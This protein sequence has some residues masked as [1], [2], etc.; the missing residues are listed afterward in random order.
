MG[1][2][3]LWIPKLTRLITIVA[4]GLGLFGGFA[5]STM[6]GGLANPALPGSTGVSGLYSLELRRTPPSPLQDDGRDRR[7]LGELLDGSPL[8]R[9]VIGSSPAQA[10]FRYQGKRMDGVRVGLYNGDFF[11]MLGVVPAMGVLPAASGFGQAASPK[12]EIVLGHDL[13]RSMGAPEIGSTIE[14]ASF[15]SDAKPFPLLR[16]A[17]VAPPG[18]AGPQLRSAQQAWLAWDE[19]PGVVYPETYSR[20]DA[21]AQTLNFVAID[22][23]G[24][25]RAALQAELDHL[26]MTSGALPQQEGTL[27]LEPAAA[28]PVRARRE[29]LATAEALRLGTLVLVILVACAFGLDRWLV[30]SRQRF[31]LSIRRC[32]GESPGRS[33]G[34][35]ALGAAIDLAIA[36]TGAAALAWA[37]MSHYEALASAVFSVP[38]EDIPPLQP[39]SGL[40]LG[41]LMGLMG[42]I[43]VPLLFA[44]ELR[45]WQVNLRAAVASRQRRV[46]SVAAG[47]G[48]MLA[49]MA[50]SLSL[51][52][53]AQIDHWSRAD[54]GFS[55]EGARLFSYASDD[56][57]AGLER[58]L[59][60]EPAAPEADMFREVLAGRVAAEDIV[61]SSSP[62]FGVRQVVQVMVPGRGANLPVMGWLNDVSSNYFQRFRIRLLAGGMFDPV[63]RDE[64]VINQTMARQFFASENPIGEHLELL[65][66]TI[67]G[68]AQRYR[69]AGVVADAHYLDPRGG[70]IPMIYRPLQSKSGLSSVTVFGASGN[71]LAVRLN[72]A[73][74]RIEPHW[75]LLDHGDGKGLIG[76]MLR[77]SRVRNL[78]LA[79]VLLA[80]L[81]L[82]ALIL[83]NTGGHL[84]AEHRREVAIMRAL[85]A[86]R[87]RTVADLVRRKLGAGLLAA[88]FGSLLIMAV[89]VQSVW[90]ELRVA[91]LAGIWVMSLAVLGLF[92]ALL[93][94]AL[95]MQID[96]RAIA[97]HLVSDV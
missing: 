89:V 53:R 7:F 54:L 90:P 67:D 20:T 22:G 94:F 84:L 2:R 24:M 57:D 8:A 42:L 21:S 82:A 68:M 96:D 15:S 91:E 83:L 95:A 23:R 75:H 44:P 25:S 92:S 64:I 6:H 45:Q 18:F 76:F 71:D 32:L 62:P 81:P 97:Q 80:A 38:P 79:A 72:D 55:L 39:D 78:V 28:V 93:G 37:W 36:A 26:G 27:A 66:A 56:A 19:W 51:G 59:S 17:G 33:V 16:V 4:L 52:G 61:F 86:S 3:G 60:R 65:G 73:L 1:R 88:V 9:R 34:R 85:G 5:A 47:V 35:A 29:L 11:R 49:L 46:R 13:W 87:V 69:V 50:V 31:E 77:E 10:G 48:V 12:R 43:A 30:W 58:T 63:A 70:P 74:Q 40:I 41:S 14:A